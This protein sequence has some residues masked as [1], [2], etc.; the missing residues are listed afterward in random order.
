MQSCA[1]IR[2]MTHDI[3]TPAVGDTVTIGQRT[4]TFSIALADSLLA[5]LKLSKVSAIPC[6]ILHLF[7]SDVTV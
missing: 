6:P 1:S 5:S 4:N 3:Y 7:D 2:A